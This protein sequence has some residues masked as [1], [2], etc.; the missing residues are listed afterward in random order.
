[1]LDVP[2]PGVLA[3]DYGPVNLPVI[4]TLVTS[5]QHGTLKLHADGGFTYTPEGGFTGED[6][7]TYTAAPAAADSSIKSSTATVTIY[8]MPNGDM[9]KVIIGGNQTTTDESGPQKVTDWATVISVGDNGQP[10]TFTVTTDNPELF[11]APPTIDATGQLIYTPAP[12]A[13]GDATITVVMH[14]DSGD[15]TQSFTIHVDKPHPLYNALNRYDVNNDKFL[16]PNDVMAVIN[17]LNAH[18]GAATDSAEGEGNSLP[19]LD[20]SRDNSIDPI[21]ALMIINAINAGFGSGNGEPAAAVDSL[22]TGLLTLVA[23]DTAEA[24]VGR[25]RSA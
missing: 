23:Q 7:F 9:P 15:T 19:Y 3:N 22:D 5:V 21:D 20:V 12:N 14:D 11:A 6:R 18:G 25:K 1:M 16:A 2:A 10:A 4:A 24:T 13:S 17:Y 8:V